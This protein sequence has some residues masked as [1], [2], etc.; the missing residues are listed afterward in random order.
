MTTAVQVQY[1]RGTASQ[2]A[3]FTGAAGELVVD[4]TNN[5]VVT[6]DGTTAGGY[7]HALVANLPFGGFKN[8]MLGNAAGPQSFTAPAAPNNQVKVKAD[9]LS[10]FSSTLGVSALLSSVSLTGDITVSGAGGLDTGTVAASTWYA[11][12]VI[13]GASGSAALFSTSAT[14]PTL[15]SGYTYLARVGWCRTDA[16]S[17]IL[18][19]L[20]QGRRAKWVVGTNP[21]VAL[22]IVSGFAGTYSLTSPTLTSVSISSFAPPTAASIRIVANGDWKNGG[23]ANILVAPS[24]AWGGTNNGPSGSNGGSYPFC[25]GLTSGE[26]QSAFDV[27]LEGTMIAWASNATSGALSAFG[28]EDNL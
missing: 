26:V 22:V 21:A 12:F 24:M 6:Q 1:R 25:N 27:E 20:Q 8:L 19:F 5:R 18:W 7:P 28:W 13:S 3:T 15:P 17:H 9:Y 23:L 4:T 2:V 10:V 16:S 14:S 11:I